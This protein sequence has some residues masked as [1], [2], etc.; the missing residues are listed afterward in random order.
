MSGNKDI[1]ETYKGR[2]ALKLGIPIV[3][4]AFVDDCIEKQKALD[5]EEYLVAGNTS[6]KQFSCGIIKGNYIA[7]ETKYDHK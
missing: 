1:T 6:A 7:V 3:S 4:L 5:S 2:A